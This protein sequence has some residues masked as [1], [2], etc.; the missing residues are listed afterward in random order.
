MI[1]TKIVDHFDLSS[2]NME[3]RTIALLCP[4]NRWATKEE[5]AKKLGRDITDEDLLRNPDWLMQHF[6]ENGGAEEFAK[7]RP[8]FLRKREIKEVVPGPDP[9]YAI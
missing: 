4:L 1:V 9:E 7:R 6:N 2:Y 5:W 3:Q 8:E